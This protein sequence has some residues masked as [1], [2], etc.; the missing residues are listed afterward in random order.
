MKSP[1]CGRRLGAPIP[2]G[3]SQ[4][5]RYNELATG[6]LSAAP[7]LLFVEPG[8]WNAGEQSEAAQSPTSW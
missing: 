6:A 8:T 4:S 1:E 5:G 3:R 2:E 7:T